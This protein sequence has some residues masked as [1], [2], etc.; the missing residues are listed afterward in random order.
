METMKNEMDRTK[1]AIIGVV[2][3]LMCLFFFMLPIVQFT[4]DSSIAFTGWESS[5]VYIPVSSDIDGSESIIN[6]IFDYL[7]EHNKSGNNNLRDELNKSLMEISSLLDI[8]IPNMDDFTFYIKLN[9]VIGEISDYYNI[10]IPNRNYINLLVITLLIIP[11]L[12]I[13][14]VF[15][16][17]SLRFLRNILL[18][19]VLFNM[20]FIIIIYGFL[21]KYFVPTIFCWIILAFYI[22][23]YVFSHSFKKEEE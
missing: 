2:A 13:V 6:D 21:G 14:L 19:G 22:G 1:R 8:D 5:N 10:D 7:K 11:I 17:V 16:K 3:F 15:T 18:I 12:V 20:A 9:K 23:T 4:L